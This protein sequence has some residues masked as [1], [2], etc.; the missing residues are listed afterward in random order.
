MLVLSLDQ[1]QMTV[2]QQQ[3]ALRYVTVRENHVFPHLYLIVLL[4]AHILFPYR[5][6][7]C[8]LHIVPH[9]QEECSVCLFSLSTQKLCHF[10]LRH[11]LTSLLCYTLSPCH[12]PNG[13]S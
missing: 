2:Q 1:L 3:Q 5:T 11:Q 8:F 13:T 6:L 9:N 4:N 10:T 7:D 12:T